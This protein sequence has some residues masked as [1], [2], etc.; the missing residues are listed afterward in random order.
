MCSALY[1]SANPGMNKVY[2]KARRLTGV[3]L[4]LKGLKIKAL[5]SLSE[6]KHPTN[7]LQSLP[8]SQ[9][10]VHSVLLTV[11]NIPVMSGML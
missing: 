1:E 2:P 8:L 3:Q 4:R 7:S 6:R 9:I 10:C 5:T 11:D